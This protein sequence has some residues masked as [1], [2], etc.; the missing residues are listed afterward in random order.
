[1]YNNYDD[2]EIN[3]ECIR[4]FFISCIHF[5][6]K[7]CFHEQVILYCYCDIIASFKYVYLLVGEKKTIKHLVPKSKHL[8]FNLN[9]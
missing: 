8:I 4:L 1:M 7:N 2:D 9:F 6:R 3:I 5:R